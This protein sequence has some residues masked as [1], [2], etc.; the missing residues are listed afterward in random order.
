MM[1]YNVDNMYDLAERVFDSLSNAELQE[2]F[3]HLA[4]EGYVADPDAFERDRRVHG[5]DGGEE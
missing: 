2:W 4:V 5:L 1:E 3:I